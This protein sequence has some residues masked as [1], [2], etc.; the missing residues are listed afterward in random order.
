MDKQSKTND[1]QAPRPGTDGRTSYKLIR[2][3]YEREKWNK[4]P[5]I[6][7]TDR[8]GSTSVFPWNNL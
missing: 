5:S 7:E 2:F 3:T 4:K 6:L 1:Q 8:R